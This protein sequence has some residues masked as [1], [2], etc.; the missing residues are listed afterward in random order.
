MPKS[1]YF[2]LFFYFF[3]LS[4]CY[5]LPSPRN[6]NDDHTITKKEA[7]KNI[8]NFTFMRTLACQFEGFQA[9]FF[10]Q[11]GN[12]EDPSYKSRS[13]EILYERRAVNAC[14]RSILALPCPEFPRNTEQA[15]RAMTATIVSNRYLNCTFKS[16]RF[17]E[18]KKPLSG[19]FW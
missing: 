1:L 9:L 12:D 8:A 13:D 5:F 15:V 6:P 18:F 10:S 2:I 11:L 17:F 19:T 4:H 3:G 14:L 16:M 7:E